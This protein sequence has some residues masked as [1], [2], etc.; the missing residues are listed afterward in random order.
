LVNFFSFLNTIKIIPKVIA[1]FADPSKA[2]KERVAHLMTFVVDRYRENLI[3]LTAEG[4]MQAF[5][6]LSSLHDAKG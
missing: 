1:L 3:T 6:F 4:V 5:N 2:V